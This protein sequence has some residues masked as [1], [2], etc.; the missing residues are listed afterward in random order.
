MRLTISPAAYKWYVDELNLKPGMG[1][2]YVG[3]VYGKTPVHEGMSLGIMKT[4]DKPTDV[5][6]EVVIDDRYFWVSNQDRWFF[7]EYDLDVQF[8]DE[9]E[10]P[11]Y[12]YLLDGK[13]QGDQTTGASQ[14][15]G[16]TGA[17]I[18]DEP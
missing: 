14:H 3:K 12:V 17:S 9:L 11:E 6:A 2:K 5:F 13:V 10:E 8:N 7:G 4:F 1:V 16:T 15:D 18:H